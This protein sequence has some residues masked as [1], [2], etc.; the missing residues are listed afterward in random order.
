MNAAL[1]LDPAHYTY[2]VTWSAEDA[3]YLATCSELPSL[4]WLATTPEEALAGVKRVVTDAVSDMRASGEHVPQPLA[5]RSYSGHFN[6]R[7]SESLHRRLVTEAA[8]EGVSL[9]RLIS[10]RLARA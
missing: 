1:Q 9:N 10:E 4:S 6:V 7:V 2:R 3:E 8:E 5:D